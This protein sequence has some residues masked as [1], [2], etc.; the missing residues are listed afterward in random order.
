MS[1]TTR[2]IK[3]LDDESVADLRDELTRSLGQGYRYEVTSI[4]W[5]FEGSTVLGWCEELPQ[6][7]RMATGVKKAPGCTGAWIFDRERNQTIDVE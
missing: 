2:R 1:K 6:A 3:T 7:H 4:G 5:P